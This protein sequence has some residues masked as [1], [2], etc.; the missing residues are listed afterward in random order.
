MVFIVIADGS[1]DVLQA[2]GAIR[3]VGELARV[4][5]TQSGNTPRLEQV[6]M[7]LVPQDGLVTA[8]AVRQYRR[9]VAHGSGC[10]KEGGFLTEHL[11][12]QL[13]QTVYGGVIP[14]YVVADLSPEHGFSHGGRGVA[15]R[16]GTQ[17]D[18]M[19]CGLHICQ[20]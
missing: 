3:L 12:S 19:H 7:R 1:L 20:G 6:G 14:V 11:G 15:D 18:V 17:V 9:Q 8:P 5:P 4:H 16:I 2:Q 10:D 13:L